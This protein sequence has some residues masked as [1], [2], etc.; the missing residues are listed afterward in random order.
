[1]RID[2]HCHIWSEDIPAPLWKDVLVEF[3]AAA[4]GS[5]RSRVE[6]R[7]ESGLLDITG[8][9][10]VADMDVA[11]IDKAVLLFLDFALLDDRG[12]APPIDEQHDAFVE[13]VSNH[14]DRLVAFAGID[15]RRNGAA[16]FIDGVLEE[17]AFRGVKLHPATG[18][19]PNASE[20]SPIYDVC[21]DH[22]VPVVIH[23]GPEAHPFYAKYGR[24]VYVDDVA[25][26]YP[27]LDIIMAHAGFSRWEAAADIAMFNPN[28]SVD[29]A[30]WQAKALRRPA[31]RVYRQLRW[32]LDTAGP[33]KVL[34]GTDWP[35]FRLVD[36]VD[37]A[38]W[39]ETLES[40]PSTPPEEIGGVSF[41]EHEIDRLLGENAQELIYD[42]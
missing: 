30:Y 29:I 34:F 4:S 13:A 32:L 7:V 40:L 36:A 19:Y 37:H 18:F 31:D 11:G 6:E 14:P 39:F 17:P 9:E 21:V 35:A 10:L 27:E 3:G 12:A 5:P 16:E 8:D 22:D 28:I 33:E 20:A 2:S 38:T 24:P 41:S 26:H 23:T 25:S 15:P 42:R 1:M